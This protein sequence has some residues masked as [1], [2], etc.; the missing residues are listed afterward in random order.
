MK[1][2]NTVLITGISGG[3]AKLTASLLLK[4]NPKIKIIGVDSRPLSTD[5][6]RS[7]SLK[8]KISFFQV[9]YTRGHF[10][11]LFRDHHFDAVLHLGRLSHARIDGL[12]LAQRLDLN[13]MGTGK[14][15]ELSLKHQIK[16]MI[17]LSTYHVYGALNDNPVY[18]AEDAP[19][20]ASIKYPELRDVV[21]MDQMATNW[22]WKNQGKIDT[23]VLR[24]CNILGP[25]I[26][27]TMTRYLQSRFA[28]VPI[29]YNPMYQ[30][31]HEFDMARII[32][33]SLKRFPTGVYNVATDET[34]SLRDAKRQ[35]DVPFIPVPLIALRPATKLIKL[36]WQ[37]PDYLLD[38][39]QFS[40]IIDGTHLNELLPEHFYHFSIK[41]TL[42]QI[43]PIN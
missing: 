2:I 21:E 4:D 32:I 42:E 10:E 25:Q 1:D 24:P 30:F 27:N 22:M 11:S 38:Y 6:H 31:I 8:D 20:R 3:L 14:I 29:D 36:L 13:V 34:I 17:I 18:L 28:P 39:I 7:L 33:E 16:R 43:R 19:L 41:D 5:P 40:S 26:A 23:V 15:L 12:S 35:I 37:F 9:S